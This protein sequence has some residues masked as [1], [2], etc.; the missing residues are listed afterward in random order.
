MKIIYLMFLL[1]FFNCKANKSY[2]TINN[3]EDSTHRYIEIKEGIV[4]R[5]DEDNYYLK[6]QC[7][8]I[9][10]QPNNYYNCYQNEIR[11]KDSI[12]KVKNIIDIKSFRKLTDIYFQDTNHIYSFREFPQTYPNLIVLE[13]DNKNF[14]VVGNYI[15]DS[16]K[17]YW[18]DM[19][20]TNVH[21][22]SFHMISKLNIAADKYKIFIANESVNFQ[23]FNERTDNSPEKD[24][25]IKIYFPNN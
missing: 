14:K 3:I 21:P 16:N 24:S 12:L 2:K 18:Y 13:I 8:D 6:M 1:L 17:V 23:Q 9:H 25:L 5:D 15:L 22:R 10:D 7:S 4:Y 19:L 11:F 20:L